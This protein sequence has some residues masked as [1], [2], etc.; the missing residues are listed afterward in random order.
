[1]FNVY[2][3]HTREGPWIRVRSQSARRKGPDYMFE[4]GAHPV[5]RGDLILIV[6]AANVFSIELLGTCEC[7]TFYRV[8][9]EEQARVDRLVIKLSQEEQEKHFLRTQAM[10][11]EPMTGCRWHLR[12]PD[13][14]IVRAF[15]EEYS[16][17]QPAARDAPLEYA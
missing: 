9:P 6:P 5:D 16:G 14:L 2:K 3:V 7:P 13:D 17:T 1:M 4:G 11:I 15:V 12:N 10:H 8:D